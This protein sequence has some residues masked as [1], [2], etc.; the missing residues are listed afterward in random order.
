[1]Q[2]KARIKRQQVIDLLTEKP[3][4][5][6]EVF[7]SLGF[8]DHRSRALVNQLRAEGIIKCTGHRK[9]G[10]A[11]ARVFG[12]VPQADRKKQVAIYHRPAPEKVLKTAEPA[13]TLPSGKVACYGVWGLA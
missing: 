9:V 5:T 10:K 7:E 4:T 3:R 1:M 8:S 2:I 11:S 13:P 6:R 12:I